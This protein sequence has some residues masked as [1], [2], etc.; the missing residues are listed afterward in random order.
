MENDVG[1]V[2][3]LKELVVSRPIEIIKV[4]R[5]G[6]WPTHLWFYVLPFATRD[7][8]GLPAFWLGAV[9]VC[10]PLGLL[11]YGWN[12]LGDAASDQINERK[13]SWIF[14]ARPT[15]PLR[16]RLPAWIAAVQLPFVI[17]M[18]W[19]AGPKMLLWFAAVL[20]VNYSY[21]TLRFKALPVLDLLNQ[22]GYLLIFVLASWLCDVPQM[23]LPAMVFSALFAMQSHLFGQ[24]MDLDADAAAGRRSTAVMLGVTRSKWLLVMI[25]LVEV[26][27][28]ASY[29]QSPLVAW[30]MSAGA[31]FFTVDAMFG[32]RRYPVWFTKAFFVI[33]N[34]LVLV[35]MH[36]VWR[37][38]LFMLR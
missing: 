21:N 23:S 20:L 11:L 19:I 5:P 27:L 2:I 12:D 8:F 38:G 37:D 25:M 22:V 34:L 13:D 6:F 28:A 1:T 26:I 33:W 15:A 31:A 16:R 29:F 17:A 9:Y 35:T 24:L 14:G 3:Q 10:F 32:P 36:W 18:V 4:A 7:V 30:F